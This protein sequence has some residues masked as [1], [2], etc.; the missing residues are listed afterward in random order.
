MC[1]MRTITIKHMTYTYTH[2]MKKKGG[3]DD[4]VEYKSSSLSVQIYSLK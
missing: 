3:V 2:R 1:K 4:G